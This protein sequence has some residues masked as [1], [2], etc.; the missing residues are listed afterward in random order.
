MPSAASQPRKYSSGCNPA[1]WPPAADVVVLLISTN[2][3][4]LGQSPADTATGI[5]A[6]VSEIGTQLP[7]TRILLLGVLPRGQSPVDPFRAAVAKVN[8]RIARLADGQRVHYLDIGPAFLQPD[9]TIAPQVMP[10]FLHPS[11]AGYRIYVA[12]I[13]QPLLAA[14]HGQ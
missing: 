4:G 10:D 13:W 9:G 7:Y 3:L 6:I 8:A 14:L 11:L 12:A 5:A 2:N 1:K